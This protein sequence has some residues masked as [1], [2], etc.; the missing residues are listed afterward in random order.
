MAGY[1]R[2][3]R[4]MASCGE[5]LLVLNQPLESVERVT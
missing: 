1:F 2:E 4:A 5:R 3:T